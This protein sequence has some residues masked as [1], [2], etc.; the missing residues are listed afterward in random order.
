MIA[1]RSLRNLLQ[2][3]LLVRAAEKKAWSMPS[4]A[5]AGRSLQSDLSGKN[6]EKCA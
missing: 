1:N 4:T 6:G 2:V 5:K 3:G